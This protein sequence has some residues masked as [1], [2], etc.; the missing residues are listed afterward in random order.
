MTMN[1]WA[2]VKIKD[3]TSPYHAQAGV[4]M[5]GDDAAAVVVRMDEDHTMQTFPADSLETLAF[6]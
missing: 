1:A 2:V 4:V 3:E 6:Q 5:N